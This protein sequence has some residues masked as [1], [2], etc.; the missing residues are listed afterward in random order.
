[1]VEVRLSGGSTHRLK[2]SHMVP[3]ADQRN[4]DLVHQNRTRHRETRMGQK[5]NG[6][7]S[8]LHE[9]GRAHDNALA[10]DD[11]G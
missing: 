7:V 8:H 9:T 6:G 2:P 4:E 5:A 10:C 11:L 1:M 3:Q